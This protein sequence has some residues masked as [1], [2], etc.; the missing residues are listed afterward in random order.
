MRSA[1]LV[2]AIGNRSDAVIPSIAQFLP[3]VGRGLLILPV[4]RALLQHAE[5]GMPIANRDYAI[6]RGGYHPTIAATLDKMLHRT[7]APPMYLMRLSRQRGASLGKF[8]II[9]VSWTGKFH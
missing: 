1:W 9:T 5:W 7:S 2:L 8:G 4:Y 3:S 6:S